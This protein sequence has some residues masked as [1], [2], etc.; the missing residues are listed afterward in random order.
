MHI[1]KLKGGL[2]NQLFQ[3]AY[4]RR[5]ELSG[6]KVVFDTSFFYGSKSSLDTSR[7]FKLTNFNI[8]TSAVFSTK[9]HAAHDFIKKI[10]TKLRIYPNGYWQSEDYFKDIADRIRDEFTLKNP[11]STE[12]SKI[13]EVISRSPKSVSLHVRRGDYITDTNTNKYHGT[14]DLK[15]YKEAIK[16]I[17]SKLGNDISIFIFS[18]DIQWVKDNLHFEQPIT[19]V[20]STK[21]LDVEELYLMSLCKHHIIANSTFS[22]WGA[23]LN[24]N[25]NKIVV[26]PQ[27]WTRNSKN[28]N[29]IIPERWYKI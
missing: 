21:I 4:G 10:L 24:P 6:K 3:Y 14:C 9:K 12:A 20:S 18:D 8:K 16:F 28:P 27:E 11:L 22:W 19:F 23:W 5:L 15:Y 2:G 29:N 25:H 13:A 26:A 1:V 17:T 7:D